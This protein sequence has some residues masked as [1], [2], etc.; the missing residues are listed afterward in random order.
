MI[1]VTQ[2]Q[3][4]LK[5][6]KISENLNQQKKLLNIVTENKLETYDVFTLVKKGTILLRWRVSTKLIDYDLDTDSPILY[7]SRV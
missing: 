2:K 4:Q 7:F 5:Q 3:I 1:Q 6:E